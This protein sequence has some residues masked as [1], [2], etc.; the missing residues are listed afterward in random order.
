MF[1][2]QQHPFARKN[3]ARPAWCWCLLL[4]AGLLS[5]GCY[6]A[7]RTGD[8][9]QP[10]E[11]A[12]DPPSG[13]L[14]AATD[15]EALPAVAVTDAHGRL[16]EPVIQLGHHAP[17]QTFQF[18]P[19]GRWL[20]TSARD[21]QVI[22]WDAETGD[23]VR[24]FAPLSTEHIEL[25]P[26][27]RWLLM[28]LPQHQLSDLDRPT[29][30]V[31]ASGI[32]SL[33]SLDTGRVLHPVRELPDGAS[34]RSATLTTD[35]RYLLL[36]DATANSRPQHCWLWD[37]QDERFVCSQAESVPSAT[38]DKPL[39]EQ[40]EERQRPF[41]FERSSSRPNRIEFTPDGRHLLTTHAQEV[42]LW[43]IGSGRPL[44]IFREH[45]ASSLTATM[46]PDGRL[47]LTTVPGSRATLWELATGEKLREFEAIPVI[48]NGRSPSV[49]NA[50]CEFSGD[51]QRVICR[52]H[53][54]RGIHQL[55]VEAGQLIGG[56]YL[57]GN[58]DQAVVYTPDGGIAATAPGLVRYRRPGTNTLLPKDAS[59]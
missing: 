14:W 13:L 6:P 56:F 35:G 58:G 53:Y 22:Q 18:S 47:L 52:S 50:S 19:D 16:V 20:L 41:H 51:G 4:V 29:D 28:M 36:T 55:C 44:H 27:G 42:I 38:S 9:T 49:W 5:S 25:T 57:L 21:S 1:D 11:A 10:T 59:E 40:P 2:H 7:V 54:N 23:L 45:G 24:S 26:D 3:T 39:P 31:Q 32:P 34:V 33:I 37:V 46:S 17:L 30:S 43:D 12:T 48:A 8:R 15:G